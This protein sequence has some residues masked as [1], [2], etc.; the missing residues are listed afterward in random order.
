MVDYL[1]EAGIDESRLTW[2]GYGK[3]VPKVVTKR[4]ATEY[5]EFPEGT[6]LNE[7]FIQGLEPEEQSKA[8]QI[9]RRT[10]FKVTSSGYEM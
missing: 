1:I 8:D 9:N 7:E 10:E 5:P 2:K 4:I 3:T 6:E